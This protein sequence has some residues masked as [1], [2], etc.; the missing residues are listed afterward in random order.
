MAV[1]STYSY[2]CWRGLVVEEK[3]GV[4]EVLGSNPAG[5]KFKNVLIFTL[6][7]YRTIA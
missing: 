6:S 5:G 3:E 2:T 4:F 1:A 7:P